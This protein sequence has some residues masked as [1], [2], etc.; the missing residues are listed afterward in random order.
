[1]TATTTTTMM[2]MIY[3]P[4]CCGDDRRDARRRER[5][6][7]I[8]LYYYH[9]VCSS[10]LGVRFLCVACPQPVVGHAFRKSTTNASTGHLRA[11]IIIII[12]NI[13]MMCY[14]MYNKRL[15]AN[16]R[17][18][19]THRVY[20]YAWIL[21]KI[22][23]KYAFQTGFYRTYCVF[24]CKCACVCVCRRSF[25]VFFFFSMLFMHNIINWSYFFK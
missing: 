10:T 24:M 11:I 5:N 14:Q 9:V 13:H 16:T 21:I 12:I 6:I 25:S 18:V 17:F 19:W 3:I 23:I 2:M 15:F 20:Y 8:L 1:M 4:V 22:G 7:R